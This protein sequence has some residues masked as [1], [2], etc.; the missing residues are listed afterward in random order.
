MQQGHGR[1]QLKISR[2]A[3]AA[4]L[5]LLVIH[6]AGDRSDPPNEIHEFLRRADLAI[7]AQSLFGA[8]QMGRAEK[9]RAK[10]GRREHGG[11]HG[12]RGAFSLGARHMH[13]RHALLRLAKPR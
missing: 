5:G 13:D 3:S 11:D 8:V 7:D 2:S 10:A 4:T 6:G 1:G 9:S 12:R